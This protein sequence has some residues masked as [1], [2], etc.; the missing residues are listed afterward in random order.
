MSRSTLSAAE[1]QAGVLEILCYLL[2]SARGVIYEP[3]LYAPY[4]LAD[5]ARRLILLMDQAGIARPDW[6][7]IAGEIERNVMPAISDEERCKEILD[8]LVLKLTAQMK[9]YDGDL[10]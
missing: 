1:L 8:G 9:A 6:R 2:A 5:G 7:E 3:R 10:K 4:R